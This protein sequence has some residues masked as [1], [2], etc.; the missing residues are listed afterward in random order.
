MVAA[1]SVRNRRQVNSVPV[2][3]RAD[4]AL[5]E[6]APMDEALIAVSELAQL[7]AMRWYP[8]VGFSLGR[9]FDQDASD[10]SRGGRPILG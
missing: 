10:A 3:A 4:V 9:A 2:A 5:V 6:D 1:W 8:Q 7:A